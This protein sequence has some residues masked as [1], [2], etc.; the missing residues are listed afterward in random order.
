M[1]V[2]AICLPTLEY[3]VNKIFDSIPTPSHPIQYCMFIN[4]LLYHTGW[5]NHAI[6]IVNNCC[7]LQAVYNLLP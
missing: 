3:Q 4:P 5:I 2:N 6:P 1:I 7:S